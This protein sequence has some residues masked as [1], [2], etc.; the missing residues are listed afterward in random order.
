M[1]DN[2]SARRTDSAKLTLQAL[3]L[4]KEELSI[5]TKGYLMQV[6]YLFLSS[7]LQQPMIQLAHR[8]HQGM[9]KIKCRL[10]DKVWFAEHDQSVEAVMR[11]CTACQA[12]NSLNLPSPV[13]MEE[14]A[15][16]PW[17]YASADFGS[18]H[19][20]THMLILIDDFFRYPKVEIVASTSTSEVIPKME[21]VMAI[22]G[23][24]DELRTDNG[25]PFNSWEWAKKSSVPKHKT[26]V[27]YPKTASNQ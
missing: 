22:Y 24:I 14:G 8:A 21:K 17:Q 19:N 6:P 7:S 12:S 20:G 26:P 9:G 15:K 3:D 16:T 1:I 25:L 13:I 11:D 10:R 23:L 5:T 18:L 2:H 27:H 4:V